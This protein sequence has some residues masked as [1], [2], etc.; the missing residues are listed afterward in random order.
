M[1]SFSIVNSMAKTSVD[2][3][4][5][6]KAE[7]LQESF[8]K[9]SSFLQPNE[10]SESLK[11]SHFMSSSQKK[12]RKNSIYLSPKPFQSFLIARP[13]KAPELNIDNIDENQLFEVF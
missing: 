9:K 12:E 8:I 6:N 4:F 7:I 5:I 13:S 1:K 10:K 3:D 2:L 11:S